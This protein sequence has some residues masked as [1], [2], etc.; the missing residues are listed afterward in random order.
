MGKRITFWRGALM[1]AAFQYFYDPTT[2]HNRRARLRQE[3]ATL[4]SDFASSIWMKGR[5][6]VNLRRRE[7]SLV[8]RPVPD[9]RMGIV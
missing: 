1:G 7:L 5:D 9:M 2:G 4:M 6:Q 3:A 8:E